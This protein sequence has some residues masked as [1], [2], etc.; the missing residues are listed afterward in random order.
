[1]ARTKRNLI[2]VATAYSIYEVKDEVMQMLSAQAMMIP[3]AVALD[4][5]VM[6]GLAKRVATIAPYDLDEDKETSVTLAEEY[7]PEEEEE[8]EPNEDELPGPWYDQMKEDED[9]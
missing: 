3:P 2:T 6:R 5:L 4:V 1:M 9:A 7:D 8:E